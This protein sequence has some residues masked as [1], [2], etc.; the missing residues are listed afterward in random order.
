[1]SKDTARDLCAP[2]SQKQMDFI[3]SDTDITVFGGAAGSGK[4]QPLDSKVLT[5]DGFVR[6]GDIEVG[7]K[8]LTPTNETVKVTAI[9]PHKSKAIYHISVY[10]GLGTKACDEHLWKALYYDESHEEIV[11]VYTTLELLD[12][13]NNGADVFIPVFN[14]DKG[15]SYYKQLMSIMFDRYDEAQCITVDHP[16]HLY[17]TDDYIVTHNTWQGLCRF[18]RF[19]NEPLYS[20][21]VIRKTQASLKGTAWDTAVRLFTAWEPRVK[22]NK[23]EMTFKFPSGCKITFKGMDGTASIEY[24][25]GQEISGVLVDEA[26]QI[27]YEEVSWLLTRLRTNSAAKPTAWFTCNPSPDHFILKWVE[28]YLYPKKTYVTDESGIQTDI[29]GRP[30]PERNGVIRWYYVIDGLWVW[31]DSK[32]ELVEKYKDQV[33]EGQLPMSFRF[34]G[35]TYKDNPMISKKYVSDLMNKTRIEKE[36]LVFG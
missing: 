25:Q 6:M 28:W 8:V 4:A 33:E 17:I 23:N 14:P 20:G 16:D 11:G 29:G 35:A 36:Q 31:G 18:L 32:E 3:W 7:S 9:Y 26:T 22:I 2:K 30:N 27:P 1:M 13:L 21:F 12:L 10:G 34:I 15:K 19:V 5:P 24:F